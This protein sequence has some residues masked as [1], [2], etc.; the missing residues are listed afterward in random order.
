MNVFNITAFQGPEAPVPPTPIQHTVFQLTDAKVICQPT[1][2]GYTAPVDP[3][4]FLL[5]WATGARAACTAMMTAMLPLRTTTTR[6]RK[7]T[8]TTSARSRYRTE[9]SVSRE[10]W[11]LEAPPT[12]P[13]R[14]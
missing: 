13:L 1:P 3:S 9:K 10:L 11:P 8:T 4:N 5:P 2:D 12:G 7:R 6:K 14:N